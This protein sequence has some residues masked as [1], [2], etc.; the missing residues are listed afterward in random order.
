MSHTSAALE[1]KVYL[2]AGVGLVPDGD[3]A[4]GEAAGLGQC[5]L[6]QGDRD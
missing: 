2:P 4:A 6:Q 5:G 3:S 1:G